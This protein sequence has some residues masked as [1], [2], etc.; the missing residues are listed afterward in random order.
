MPPRLLAALLVL[1]ALAARTAVAQDWHELYA[2][3]Q[4]ALREGR[5]QR[6][7]DLLN[8][9]IQKR[10]EPGL[11]VPTYG[12]NIEPRYFPYLRLAEAYFALEKYD[13]AAAALATSA[14]YGVAPAAER[15][16]LDARVRAAIDLARPPTRS[17]AVPPPAPPPPP[18][19][20]TPIPRAQ[21]ESTTPSPVPPP[22]AVR[23][24]SSPSAATTRPAPDPVRTSV[25]GR[26][27]PPVLAITSDPAGAQVYVDDE[28]LGRTDPETGRLRITTL[29]PGRHRIR[30][31]AE[32]RA[33]LVREIDLGDGGFALEG[34]LAPAAAAPPAS[35]SAGQS[36]GIHPAWFL[37]GF[38]LVAVL[39]LTLWFRRPAH[40]PTLTAHTP[41]GLTDSGGASA[42][43]S[44]EELP[45]KFADYV[46]LRRIGRGGMATVYEAER[47]GERFALKRPLTGFLDNPRFLERFL[48]EAGLGR[49]LHHPNIVRIHD[50][51]EVDGVPYF[52]MELVEGETLRDRLDRD[53]H[54]DPVTATRIVAQ[55]TEALDYAHHK[56]VIH[57]DLKPSNI[58][59]DRAGTAKVMDYG[60]ARAQF[61][62][63]VTTT[64]GFLGTPHYAAPEA[65]DTRP[66]PRSDVYSLGIVFFEMLTG[67]LPFRGESAMAVLHAKTSTEPPAPSSINYAVPE[68]LD[69]IVLRTLAREPADRPTAEELLNQLKD[70]L[71][72]DR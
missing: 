10:R 63:G 17:V 64:G 36:G 31:A 67:S 48:R 15:T 47:R 34:V 18:P 41:I 68:T 44:F 14:R 13:E 12:T 50:R 4:R 54:L 62:D 57:R 40:Y 26:R 69:R 49:T 43:G 3:G 59:L 71:E 33:D 37:G 6:A 70:S 20:P 19:A 39:G 2:D 22:A 42:G 11:N 66:E 51:G 30:I 52:A 45:A 60:I 24:D 55:V 32:G 61:L 53:G 9:A 58:M 29:E 16:A 56:G 65:L 38:L 7:V 1:V 25:P 28:P 5:A 21:V 35:D 23:A 27:A 46:L 8:R 72:P